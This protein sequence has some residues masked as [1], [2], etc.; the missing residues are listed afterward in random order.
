[1]IQVIHRQQAGR[2]VARL[3]VFGVVYPF[4]IAIIMVCRLSQLAVLYVARF[5]WSMRWAVLLAS[6]LAAVLLLTRAGI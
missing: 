3:I 4:L 6:A 1:M 5:L 2:V